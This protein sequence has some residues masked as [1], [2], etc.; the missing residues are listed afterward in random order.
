MLL[1]GP[2]AARG[3]TIETTQS[4]KVEIYTNPPEGFHAT[5]PV[6]IFSPIDDPGSCV[7]CQLYSES[8]IIV[9]PR[10]VWV[11]VPTERVEKMRFI[12][13]P[14]PRQH[15]QIQNHNSG[16]RLHD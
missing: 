11:A 15:E 12:E 2:R 8:E 4:M 6:K 3:E 16:R 9:N 13:T 1:A 5:A 10:K 7:M 14:A